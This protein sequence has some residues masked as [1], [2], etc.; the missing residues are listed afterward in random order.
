MK[1]LCALYYNSKSYS[2]HWDRQ[3]CLRQACKYNFDLM[4]PWPLTAWPQ[5]WS[6]YALS[7][8]FQNIV[9]KSLLTDE[10]TDR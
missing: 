4:W 2:T 6:F 8:Y 10:Q 3:W 7:P 9:F 5:S 1:T